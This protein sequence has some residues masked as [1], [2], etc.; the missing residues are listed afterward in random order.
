MLKSTRSD[1]LISASQAIMKG[2]CPDGGLFVFDDQTIDK[3]F[4]S[5]D[6]VS[7][8]YQNLSRKVFQALLDD[9][10]S[11]EIDEIVRLTYNKEH[12]NR[13]IVGIDTF[14]DESYLTL[15]HGNTYAFK[16]LALSCLPNLMSVAKAKNDIKEK[17]LILTATSG[18]T[19]SATLAGFKDSKDTV[20]IVLYPSGGVSPFQELQMTS[21]ENNTNILIP[22]EGNFDDCQRIV[23]ELFISL[24]PKHIRLGSANS[25]NIGRII[26]QIVYYIHAYNQLVKNKVIS[27]GDP[28][29][30]TVPTGNFGNIYSAFLAKQMG[31]P[32]DK[33]VI[34]SN[35]NNVLTEL[36]QYHTYNINRTLKRTISPSMDILISSNFERY[37][38]HVLDRDELR[39]SYYMKRLK[40]D[41]MIEIDELNQAKDI[42]SF[43]ASEEET[44]AMIRF[45]FDSSGYLIDPH[46]AVAKCVANKY[47]SET[48]SQNHMLI[49]STASPLKFT[50][51][52]MEALDL[53]ESDNVKD[54]IENL[55]KF[56]N[57]NVPTKLLEIAKLK[58]N[59][60][61][62]TIEEAVNKIKQIVGDLDD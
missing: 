24:K 23:K 50:S 5:K 25:I 49:V 39:V 11:Q 4:Y 14:G 42:F 56:S 30:V 34:A 54:N 15:Y 10:T 8:T 9:Y 28:I 62:Y 51:A 22:V 20:V 7:L 45:V 32:I 40:E 19:G 12:F 58:P 37:L 13:Q 29:D 26:P 33:L 1:T 27:F 43:D 57:L 55:A 46:T 44:K 41:H 17:T 2:L 3:T 6:L 35:E 36:F 48:S 38:Y 52:V 31:L 16:D 59:T 60:E 53:S 47:R 21:F 18:D 61:S